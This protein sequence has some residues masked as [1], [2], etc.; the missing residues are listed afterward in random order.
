MDDEDDNN[1]AAT[2]VPEL[3]LG[4]SSWST[5]T[6]DATSPVFGPRNH[7]DGVSTTTQETPVDPSSQSSPEDENAASSSIESLS[8]QQQQRQQ[9]SLSGLVPDPLAAVPQESTAA[10]VVVTNEKHVNNY[11]EKVAIE[12]EQQSQ[13]SELPEVEEQEIQSSN[14][15]DEETN[16]ALLMD[17]E[18]DRVLS[19][20]DDDEDASSEDAAKLP[21]GLSNLGNT[22][23][24]ASALQ[25]LAS[26]EPLMNQLV[27][28]AT[29]SQ[30][31]TQQT[32]S[33][34]TANTAEQEDAEE[35]PL[36]LTAWVD[37]LQR[38]RKGETVHPHDLKHVLDMRTPLFCG[39]EQQD[40]HEFITTLLD[41][42][43]EDLKKLHQQ[44]S[45]T[46]PESSN[47][48]GEPALE[49]MEV[50]EPQPLVERESKVEEQPLVQSEPMEDDTDEIENT[51]PHKMT[52][53]AIAGVTHASSSYEETAANKRLK[54][55]TSFLSS[56][57][58]S[59][60]EDETDESS[61]EEPPREPQTPTD[62]PV[63]SRAF[64]DLNMDEIGVLLHG[65]KKD[66]E[67]ETSSVA[68]TASSS[69]SSDPQPKCKLVGGRMNLELRHDSVVTSPRTG[70]NSAPANGDSRSEPASGN[71]S[72]NSAMPG[73]VSDTT[74]EASSSAGNNQAS[75]TSEGASADSKPEYK[76]PVDDYLTMEVRARLTCDSCKYTRSHKETFSHLS[77]ELGGDDAAGLASVEDGLA[78]F[79]APEQRQLKCEKCFCETA[80]QTMQITK[81]PR[82][83]LLH[84]K[85][86]IVE[87]S[88]DY[89]SVSYRKNTS[90]VSFDTCLHVSEHSFAH[91][92]LSSAEM[93]VE[94]SSS[95]P[96]SVLSDFL[97]PDCIVPRCEST[98]GGTS[99]APYQK[100]GQH[101]SYSLT[102][103]VNHIGSSASCGHYT[104]D[105][106]REDSWL[107]F[108]DSYVSRITREQATE[109][110]ASTAYMLMYEMKH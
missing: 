106:V 105:A 41:L 52:T 1:T 64:S 81:L 83:L 8:E 95:P 90:P 7:D 20:S 93:Y 53:T 92:D 101:H 110:A 16:N 96:A 99:C 22:C 62:D 65:P 57:E 98:P 84:F 107:R 49:D 50:D 35:T 89:T 104:A 9:P 4:E 61:Q 100:S 59:M 13:K 14:N 56:S 67:L 85:R 74:E 11:D 109:E 79:F 2:S 30:P 71:P 91:D 75:S 87:V 3:D 44:Q 63:N 47:L 6:S 72:N 58:D 42:L 27:Q 29:A 69:S 39:Y 34:A 28:A 68:T 86:F 33:T 45:A 82:A 17:Q 46:E 94:A 97:A 55:E 48:D 60:T 31:T 5:T 26:V 102:S 23:Y 38:L 37:V 76:S 78:R 80:T 88:E 103:V 73:K 43:D 51:E 77:L 21:G 15:N 25:M 32:Q 66:A 108:N 10:V 36:V 19:M 70:E 24:M 12:E 40:S 18:M 54:T